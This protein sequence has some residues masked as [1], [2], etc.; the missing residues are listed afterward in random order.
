MLLWVAWLWHMRQESHQLPFHALLTYSQ[1]NQEPPK[2]ELKS[3]FVSAHQR[4]SHSLDLPRAAQ[5]SGTSTD[6]QSPLVS[7]TDSILC[8]A[9]T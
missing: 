7:I 6:L 4:G 9:P 3:S 5:A 8:L 1:S 2:D